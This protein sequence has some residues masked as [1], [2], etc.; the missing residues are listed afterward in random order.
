M[1]LAEENLDHWLSSATIPGVDGL[2]F[3]G[4]FDRRITFY[5]Q[6]VRALRLAR[7]MHEAG[8]TDANGS[9]AVVGAG[10]AGVT[11]AL[12]LALLDCRVTLFD[13]ADEVLQLQSD[14][15]RLLHPHIYEWP[16]LGSLEN[17]A[18]LPFLNWGL[19]TGGVVAAKL[20]QEFHGHQARLQQNLVWKSRHELT[21]LTQEGSEWRLRFD[22][23]SNFVAQQVVLAMGFGDEKKTGDADVYDYW[24]QRGVGTAAIEP[25]AP[26]TYLVSG[27]GD[28]ALTDILNLMIS[29][30]EHVSFTKTFLGYFGQDVLRTTVL[31][32]HEDK[33]PE[34]DL[35]PMF[36][37][38]LHTVLGER[39]ILDSLTPLL[40]R[41]RL[42]TVNTS[43]PLLSLGR[44][45][46]LNQCMV[47]AVLAAARQAG[48]VV[49]RSAGMI[50]DVKKHA[51]GLEAFGISV[52]GVPLSE[53]F[54]HVIL[55]HGPDKKVRY[56]PAADFFEAFGAASLERFKKQPDLLAPPSLDAETYT[57][58]Y[59]RHLDKLADAAL[60]QQLAGQSARE[61]STIIISWDMATQ[62]LVQRGK[63]ELR[64]LAEQCETAP[65]T[66]TI[67]MD[68]PINRVK[69]DDFL[70]LAKASGGKILLS[71]APAVQGSW[72][73]KLP[74]APVAHSSSS[75]YPYRPIG[76]LSIEEFVD[77][78]LVRQLDAVLSK[79]KVNGKCFG[80][81][82]IAR[83]I[84]E[85]TLT[86]WH[87]WRGTLHAS[88][89]L[90]RDFLA[91]L[92]SIG[93]SKADP[94]DGDG[95]AVE[96][97][98]SALLLILA[99]HLGEPLKPAIVPRGN[100]TFDVHGLALGSAAQEIYG[101]DPLTEWSRP[102]H[103]DVDALILS[104]SAEVRVTGPDDTVLTA[105]EPGLSLS[106]ARRIKPAIVR[107][108]INWRSAL[109][110]DL[111][112][113]RKAVEEEFGRWRKRQDDDRARVL[114]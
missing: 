6:Q 108:D 61:A 3:V 2:Y 104:G 19:D 33:N 46:Q 107:N 73:A 103:W 4:T 87:D 59:E 16:S 74:S 55:R 105:G 36:Q 70:R 80:L 34:A 66:F 30:F 13:P 111:D 79:V 37:A 11:I 97:M 94:W 17:D 72:Q 27:N 93:A 20:V 67:Q 53:H 42:L 83:D 63:V 21:S 29:G 75:R 99:T 44:A 68:A 49:R 9:I 45:A 90:R 22:D 88:P 43:G 23:G 54:H 24:K 84:L 77:A 95:Q 86:T 7:A 5:S 113:W 98:A 1:K 14:S 56:R 35:E 89:S 110:T 41:D 112:T 92:G 57:F 91:W 106:V 100:L 8:K 101:G 10:A 26:A 78:S 58:F 82:H 18:G 38:D 25:K 28:G 65:A 69:A 62:S 51:D 76:A 50:S 109:S 102:E 60:K 85:E 47:Y 71:V 39:G 96:R 32:A 52:G 40:R 12:A 81:G 64:N 31:A 48:I 114:A 15:P